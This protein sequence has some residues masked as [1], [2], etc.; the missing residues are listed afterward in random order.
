MGQLAQK[1]KWAEKSFVFK[2][3]ESKLLYNAGVF[4]FG[5]KKY[6]M[7]SVRSLDW[8]VLKILV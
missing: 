1:D 3:A 6:G 8:R 4:L 7:E 5:A 2:K